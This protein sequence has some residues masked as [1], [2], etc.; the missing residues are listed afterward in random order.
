MLHQVR[1]YLVVPGRLVR[2][3]VDCLT[4]FAYSW[5]LGALEPRRV[6]Y[7]TYEYGRD[8]TTKDYPLSASAL[9]DFRVQTAPRGWLGLA[10]DYA[11]S[12]C[13]ETL[14]RAFADRPLEWTMRCLQQIPP[15][16]CKKPGRGPGWAAG[17]GAST[18]VAPDIDRLIKSAH[19][20]GSGQHMEAL[21][22][23][24]RGVSL[25]LWAFDIQ[26]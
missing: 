1:L 13:G 25:S 16:Q 18:S 19:K 15:T 24:P 4:V 10:K 20:R 22:P 8:S 12:S 17:I 26:S 14:D 6:T 21:G 2:S 7:R 5:M 3:T 11:P 9:S 23:A